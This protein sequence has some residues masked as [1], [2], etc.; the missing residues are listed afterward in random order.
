MRCV[1]SVTK[2]FFQ[3]VFVT[4]LAP[5]LGTTV[6]T[7]DCIETVSD[8]WLTSCKITMNVAQDCTEMSAIKVHSRDSTIMLGNNWTI[9][10][11]YK[12]LRW[13]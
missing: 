11:L 3:C 4:R 12:T 7:R 6:I 10:L 9:M 13:Q 5:V 2:C 8:I 1:S